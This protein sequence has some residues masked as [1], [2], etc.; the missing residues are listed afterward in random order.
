VETEPI[1]Y[2]YASRNPG[3]HRCQ[4][5]TAI[6]LGAKLAA[7]AAAAPPTATI[8]LVYHSQLPPFGHLQLKDLALL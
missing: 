6:K 3:Q 2:A 5:R 4:A 7:Q 8:P 1:T